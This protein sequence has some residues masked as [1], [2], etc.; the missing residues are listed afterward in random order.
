MELKNKPTIYDYI[1]L[2]HT[3]IAFAVQMPKVDDFG[4]VH[5]NHFNGGGKSFVSSDGYYDF[6]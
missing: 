2:N 1:Y 4:N 3:A 5:P 6:S